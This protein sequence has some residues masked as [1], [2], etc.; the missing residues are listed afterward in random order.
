MYLAQ[1][2]RLVLGHTTSWLGLGIGLTKNEQFT[3]W[4]MNVN[5]SYGLV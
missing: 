3:F 4:L 1:V 5:Q 2:H